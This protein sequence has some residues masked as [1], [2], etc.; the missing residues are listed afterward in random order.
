MFRPS[1]SFVMVLALALVLGLTLPVLA[2]EVNGTV[3]TVNADRNEVVLKGLLRDTPIQVN[4]NA[5]IVLDGSAAAFKDVHPGDRAQITVE[6]KGEDLMASDVRLLR[7]ANE[8]KGTI[9]TV[10][11]DDQITLKGFFTDTPYYL[12]LVATVWING[13]QGD[14]D[15]LRPGDEVTLTHF[16]RNNQD[17]VSEV[18][19]TRK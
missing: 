12:D 1:K 5:R 19:C 15:D 10:I 14:I 4:A 7:A 11:P 18:R 16:R 2:D 8:V 9:R 17:M 13:K 6:K 3:R